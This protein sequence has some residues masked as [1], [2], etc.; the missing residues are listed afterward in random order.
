MKILIIDD[1]AGDR[2]LA[3]AHLAEE[4]YDIVSADGGVT[5]LEAA[6][7]ERP[8]TRSRFPSWFTS[9]NRISDGLH[10]GANSVGH[11]LIT[12]WV[13]PPCWLASRTNMPMVEFSGP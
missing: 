13:N 11:V 12:V 4:G 8:T 10:P 1:S 5:G 7:C 9:A 6:A 3:E 2:A